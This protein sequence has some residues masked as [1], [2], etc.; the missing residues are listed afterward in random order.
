MMKYAIMFAVVAGLIFATSVWAQVDA[1]WD[2][3]AGDGLWATGENWTGDIAP[4]APDATARF[5][6]TGVMGVVDMNGA[7]LSV[8]DMHLSGAANGYNISSGTL[9]ATNINHSASGTNTISGALSMTGGSIAVYGGTLNLSNVSNNISGAT[10]TVGA[11]AELAFDSDISVDNLNV[12][13]TIDSA[14]ARITSTNH[15][16]NL[17]SGAVI[18]ANLAGAVELRIGEDGDWDDVV[19]AAGAHEYTG[20]TRI[21]RGALDIGDLS[22]NSLPADSYIRFEQ[23]GEE[24]GAVLMAHGTGD[25]KFVREIGSNPNNP[26]EL[27][28]YTDGGGFAARGGPLEVLLEGGNEIDWSSYTKGFW[29]KDIAFGHS[30]ADDLVTLLNGVELDAVYPAYRGIFVFDNHDTDTDVAE[31]R[32]VIGENIGGRWLVKCATNNDTSAYRQSGTLWLSN[33]ANSYSHTRIDGGAIRLSQD[34]DGLGT[35]QVQ[36]YANGHD[37]PAV[38]E[39]KGAIE[40]TIGAGAGEIYWAT[41]SSM[42]VPGDGRGGGFAAFGG[43]LDVIL[44]PNSVPGSTDLLWSSEFDGF[45]GARLHLGSYTANDVVTF[46][47]NIDGENGDREI[48]VYDNPHQSTDRAVISGD[49]TN[50]N[51]LTIR[52]D[53][54][55]EISAALNTASL[56]AAGGTT[57]TMGV[58]DISDDLDIASGGALAVNGGRLNTAKLNISGALDI[59]DAGAEVRVSESL[60]VY[61]GGVITAAPGVVIHMTGSEFANTSTNPDDLVDLTNVTLLFEGGLGDTD[62]FEVGGRDIGPVLDGFDRNFALGTLQLGGVDIGRV[63]LV[64]LHDNQPGWTGA[65]A[66]YVENLILGPGSDLDLNGINLY[67][68]QGDLDSAANVELSGGALTQVPEPATMSLLALGGLAL[69]RRRKRRA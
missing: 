29:G 27:R 11:G 12:S 69:V 20:Y 21:R 63:R 32:G 42:D 10:I 15:Y 18:N 54:I 19:V 45:S 6:G 44:H 30:V 47:S 66:I 57:S 49:L 48:W 68:L 37:Q 50:F 9:T 5:D 17:A 2:G 14:G 4:N 7:A 59:T 22:V 51:K 43:P 26:G 3:S 8:L 23:Q 60:T 52:G 38:I 64:D 41:D 56:V 34:D 46:T 55:L 65:E 33:A 39:S 35:G 62:N 13:G 53:G 25:N 40:R 36:F 67:Y 61:E 28:W 31:I 16:Y 58:L 24:Y 1:T